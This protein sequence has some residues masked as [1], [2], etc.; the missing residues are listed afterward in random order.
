MSFILF[1]K[2]LPFLLLSATAESSVLPCHLSA[3]DFLYLTTM[4]LTK[5][6]SSFRGLES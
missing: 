3:H 2:D 6:K 1:L 5:G 4:E